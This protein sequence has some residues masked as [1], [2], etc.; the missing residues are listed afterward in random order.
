MPFADILQNEY[1]NF[2]TPEN[3]GDKW[4]ILHLSLRQSMKTHITE[5]S[6][7]KGMN[8]AA[9]ARQVFERAL[10]EEGNPYTCPSTT[11]D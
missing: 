2:Y 11:H 5:H 7:A 8:N 6:L 9:C 4:D 1:D 10:T 3:P